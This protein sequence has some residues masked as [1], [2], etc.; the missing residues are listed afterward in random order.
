MRRWIVAIGL[1]GFCAFADGL[2]RP[3]EAQGMLGPGFFFGPRTRAVPIGPQ[4]QYRS[5]RRS[6]QH[7][8]R[9]RSNSGSRSYSRGG[10]DGYANRLRGPQAGFAYCPGGYTYMTPPN[11]ELNY[12]GTKY[13][14]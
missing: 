2:I 13:C 14:Y 7:T 12:Y 9:R 6:R 10:D 11:S 8:A 3:A 4:P 1:L 5:A